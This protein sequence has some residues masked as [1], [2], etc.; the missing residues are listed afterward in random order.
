[1]CGLC[2]HIDVED[3]HHKDSRMINT[4]CFTFKQRIHGPL[5]NGS[6]K[7]LILHTEYFV[8]CPHVAHTPC[9]Y[10]KLPLVVASC[11]AGHAQ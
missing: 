6:E 3:G 2:L 4:L 8:I 7:M 10:I 5:R 9:E 1:M 11:G